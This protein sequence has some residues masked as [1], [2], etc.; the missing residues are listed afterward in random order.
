MKVI[1]LAGGK[2]TRL[3]PLSTPEYP[4]QFL[5]L[6][7]DIP[8]LIATIKRF[9]NTNQ[10]DIIVITNNNYKNIT[11]NMLDEYGYNQVNIITE[12]Q[13]KNTAPA[14]ALGLKYAKEI[15]SCNGKEIFVVAPSDHMIYTA[16]KFLY[17]IENCS[18]AATKGFVAT[19]GVKPDCADTGYGYIKASGEG[20][21]KKADKFIEKP[22]EEKAKQYYKSGDY[23]WNSGIYVF[24]ADTYE[25]ELKKHQKDLYD[26]YKQNNYQKF[27]DEFKDLNSVSI[28][29]AISEKSDNIAMI[30]TDM[31]WSDIGSW[32]NFYKYSKKDEN[33]NVIIGNV[34]QQGCR[35]CLIIAKDC[36]LVVI[37]KS[38]KIHISNG[39]NNI[40]IPAGLS[41]SIKDDLYR[42]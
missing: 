41:Q 3:Y 37:D 12:P 42:E 13:A 40:C 21:I 9:K 17:A 33:G 18:N 1:I 14:I 5:K 30:S 28:D 19:I 26:I 27:I 11:Q 34:K 29:Y 2:G 6:F 10:N 15:Q 32:E 20:V 39:K 16:E 23:Y 35:N 25:N 22:C 24:T 31:V 36:E 4:K 8:M 38:A 7:D